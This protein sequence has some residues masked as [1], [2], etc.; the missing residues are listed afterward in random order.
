MNFNLKG[1]L[2]QCEMA[3]VL[4]KRTTFMLCYKYCKINVSKQ[5][6]DVFKRAALHC[7]KM[8]EH[9]LHSIQGN[10]KQVI[11]QIRFVDIKKRHIDNHVTAVSHFGIMFVYILYYFFKHYTDAKY[12][13]KEAKSN[14]KLHSNLQ[15]FIRYKVLK[16]SMKLEDWYL[17][18][19]MKSVLQFL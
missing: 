9:Q 13:L 3:Y 14:V 7:I 4:I 5:H 19:K 17:T 12:T 1:C 6:R 2:V 15:T 10:W 16:I 11:S 8:F 18:C